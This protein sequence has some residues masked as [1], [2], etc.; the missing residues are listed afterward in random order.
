VLVNRPDQ[1]YNDTKV[2]SQPPLS[3]SPM[4]TPARIFTGM[5]ALCCFSAGFLLAADTKKPESKPAEIADWSKYV[6]HSEVKAKIVKVERGGG[7][8]IEVPGQ[9]VLNDQVGRVDKALEAVQAQA[10]QA[11]RGI[12]ER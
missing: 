10:G 4:T 12:P 3:G 9:P 7:L 2:Y 6:T 11:Q 8:L 5:L 1:W